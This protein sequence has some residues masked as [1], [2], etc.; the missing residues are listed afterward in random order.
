MVQFDA[1]LSF[2][3]WRLVKP[4]SLW[5][6]LILTGLSWIVTFLRESVWCQLF[7]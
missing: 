3:A 7:R 1:H 2:E 4:R 5:I 6:Y